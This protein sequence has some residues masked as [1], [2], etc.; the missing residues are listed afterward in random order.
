MLRAISIGFLLLIFV[1]SVAA[2]APERMETSASKQS[3][4]SQEALKIYS[5][6]QKRLLAVN[7]A[8]FINTITQSHLD[9]DSVQLI[10]SRITD[11]PFMLPYTDRIEG[12]EHSATARLLNENKITASKKLSKQLKGEDQIR[13]FLLLALWYLHQPHALQ[14]DLDSAQHYAMVANN[15]NSVKPS[16]KWHEESNLI[17]GDIEY[18]RGNTD[19]SRN[20]ISSIFSSAKAGN[21]TEIEA[22]AL[23]QYSKTFGSRDTARLPYLIQS[24]TVYHRLHLVENEIVSRWLLA[25]YYMTNDRALAEDNFK[26]VLAMQ[27]SSGFRH[28][29]FTHYLLT[30]VYNSN[31]KFSDALK[32]AYAGLENMK[33]SGLN[34]FA[35]GF[36][37]RIGVVYAYVN[38]PEMSIPWYRKGVEIKS[39]ETHFF[40]YKSF[41]YL[42]TAL[43]DLGRPKE[44]IR[45]INSTITKYPPKT[46]WEK[47]Q[48]LT[49]LGYCY[50]SMRKISLADL[51]YR[52]ILNVVKNYNDTYGELSETYAQS[53][54]FYISL[55]KTSVA[56]LFLNQINPNSTTLV[57]YNTLKYSILYKID[58]LEGDFK[59]ALNDHIIY[60]Q[61]S[62]AVAGY[63]EQKKLNELTVKYAAAKKDQDIKLLHKQRDA[64]QAELK[65][66]KLIRDLM[67]IAG[68]LLALLLIVVVSRY[69]LKQRT[70]EQIT[71]KNAS[72][73]HLLT[74]KEWLLKEVHHRVK[75]NLHT[76]I[77]LLESQARYLENDAL[78]AIETSQ[79]RI[80]AMSLIH[81]KLYQSDD[82]K[83]IN[84]ADYAP[85][86]VQS[87]ID[88][89]GTA[90]QIHFKLNIEPI[91]L[92]ISHAI[93]LA[94]IINEA[95]TNSIKY[96]FPD[97]RKGEI[98]I[99]MIDDGTRIILN[100]ADDGIGMPQVNY[101]A[102]SE[103]L[104]LRLIK[105]LSEDI[106]AQIRFEVS[107][108]TKIIIVFKADPLND[109]NSILSSTNLIEGSYA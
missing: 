100:L 51:S 91:N 4:S 60:Q 97:N 77:C 58:S 28:E 89:F 30:A 27:R 5:T 33:W 66:G 73:Q 49:T 64:Q 68:C 59:A 87:L 43:V 79:H 18:Q 37:M 16:K 10:A 47:V 95:V 2:Q 105:G 82:I 13:S 25:D 3:I 12:D 76:V 42:A 6:A 23:Q 67:I 14:S 101:E 93:P 70:S 94:L 44:C 26:Q 53:A 80:F 52:K 86:L 34:Q 72:L 19:R 32:A 65:K 35:G 63:D 57:N 8:I 7:T 84:M 22:A 54:L 99:S 62:E 81:Q 71:R 85:E 98:S 104:G 40:W 21:E 69:R 75:N 45:L 20:F 9:A 107:K 36:N 11:Q 90:G 50:N 31:S 106:T 1:F 56:R 24:I 48:I 78:E 109:P 15:L 55:K 83:T 96:A 41:L 92:S 17:M 74:E 88:S 103:S 39:E 108:G 46:T 38:K 61:A 102:E 29:L